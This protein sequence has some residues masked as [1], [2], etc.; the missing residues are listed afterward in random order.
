MVVMIEAVEGDQRVGQDNLGVDRR[1]LAEFKICWVNNTKR[2]RF[3]RA[4]ILAGL[5]S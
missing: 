5:H 3:F 4:V 1:P 2:L